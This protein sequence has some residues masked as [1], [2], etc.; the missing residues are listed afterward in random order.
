ML[1]V[2][3]LI[4]SFIVF[5]IVQ[6]RRKGCSK[7]TMAQAGT[8]IRLVQHGTRW[9]R[10][11]EWIFCKEINWKKT[12][13]LVLF[14]FQNGFS[15]LDLYWY[16]SALV[17]STHSSPM[18]VIWPDKL[19]GTKWLTYHSFLFRGKA[20]QNVAIHLVQ[21]FV[22]LQHCFGSSAKSFTSGG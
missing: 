7:V 6:R 18:K 8:G 22:W 21:S 15:W 11:K 12:L 19:V 20:I 17:L 2:G 3:S 16:F 13:N 10:K 5:K 14:Q 9:R 4:R 1:K